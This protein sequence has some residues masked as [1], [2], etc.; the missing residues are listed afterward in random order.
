MQKYNI[1]A[2][3]QPNKMTRRQSL[4]GIGLGAIGLASFG[5]L[6]RT[7]LA[8]PIE[9][10]AKKTP[11]QLHLSKKDINT[12]NFA[13]NLEYLEAQYYSYATTGAGIE[14]QGAGVDGLGTQGT[15]AI[16]ANPQ[17]PFAT[18]AI[19]QYAQEIAADELAHVN[20][21]RTVLGTEAVAQP[22]IDL[23]DSFSAAA[24]A[25][26]VVGAGVTFDPFA[27]ETSFLLGAFIF[28][29][30]G[31]TAYHGAAP[32]VVNK[33]V[34]SAAAGILG[35]E[36][37]HASLVRTKIYEA[38]ASA[39]D[40]AQKISDLRDSLDGADDDDQGVTLNG[41][42]NIVPTDANG[43]VFART[44]A[45][46]LAI[47]YFSPTATSGGFFPTGVNVAAKNRHH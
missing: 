28:E 19:Q 5:G 15:V 26:G 9:D 8:A 14:A 23:M 34:L 44:A 10:A 38:G 31:V 7:A 27:D 22:A 3:A 16:K 6:M 4:R 12:L 45:Q 17:V 43:L 37:Y 30:V 32:L 2:S 25:A 47:V 24:Q 46:V 20:F 39:Q 42:A 13:L 18:P 41:V 35:T 29:D 21:L 33:K 1:V 40:A 11:G 36:A